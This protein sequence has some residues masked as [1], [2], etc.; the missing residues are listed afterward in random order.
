MFSYPY[1]TA[2]FLDVY[3][4]TVLQINKVFIADDFHPILM[5]KLRDAGIQFDYQPTANRNDVKLA[6]QAGVL[7]LV[8]RSKTQVDED[9]L[10]NSSHLAFVARGGAGMDNIDESASA[11]FGVKCFN[12]GNANSNAVGEHAV[13]MLLALLRKLH[14]ADSEVRKGIWLREE[15]RGIELAGKKVGIVGF[16]NTGSAFAKRLSGFDVEIFAYD[17][18]KKNYGNSLVKEC[19]MDELFQNAEIISFH[20]PLNGHTKLMVNSDFLQKFV[21]NIFLLNLSRGEILNTTEVLNELKNGRV[22]GFAADVL[23]HENPSKMDASDRVWFD[24]LVAHKNVILSPHIAGWTKESYEKI[25][26]KLAEQII[27]MMQS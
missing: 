21:K 23:E 3:L 9:L 1:V 18:Y 2:C 12:A 7:G 11:K 8:L 26:L 5:E 16:G 17:K 15:N 10:S 4:K 24:K 19:E 20:V 14:T 6:L 13:G 22:K 27:N 25:S